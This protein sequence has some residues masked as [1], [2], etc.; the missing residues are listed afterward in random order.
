MSDEDDSTHGGGDAAATSAIK[1]LG[2]RLPFM[3]LEDLCKEEGYEYAA[4]WRPQGRTKHGCQKIVVDG[5]SVQAEVEQFES[6]ARSA[7][8]SAHWFNNKDNHIHSSSLDR[9]R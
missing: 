5:K 2:S 8:L 9:F 3:S 1:D 6:A 7:I 4:I